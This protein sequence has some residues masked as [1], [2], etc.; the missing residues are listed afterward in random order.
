MP[1]DSAAAI[2][3]HA[4]RLRGVEQRTSEGGDFPALYVGRVEFL[5]VQG[6]RLD[7]RLPPPVQAAEAARGD[8]RPHR[9]ASAARDGWVEIELT[10]TTPERAR[11]LVE[12]AHDGAA[13]LART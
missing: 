1:E 6:T 4:K 9:V 7:V 5:H 2:I 13:R 12:M 3:A 10:A 8:V 11:A